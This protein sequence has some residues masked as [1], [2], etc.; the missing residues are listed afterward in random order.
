MRY[1]QYF[2]S[3]T[4]KRVDITLLFELLALNKNLS[5]TYF[6]LLQKK[7][8]KYI[9]HTFA[10][11]HRMFLRPFTQ[12][13]IADKFHIRKN[14]KESETILSTSVLKENIQSLKD[15]SP[16][17]VQITVREDNENT[18]YYLS[19]PVQDFIKILFSEVSKLKIPDFQY[20]IHT[21]N[22]HRYLLEVRGFYPI[23]YRLNVDQSRLSNTILDFGLMNKNGAEVCNK[24]ANNIN[25]FLSVEV[26]Q[27]YYMF[28]SP[29]MK[30]YYTHVKNYMS[31]LTYPYCIMKPIK[32]LPNFGAK[33]VLLY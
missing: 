17:Y 25:T 33:Q 19:I 2:Y 13:E 12:S 26:L 10:V 21:R 32:S 7:L 31:N 18:E 23:Q 9:F 22:I 28:E 15:N 5:E 8:E 4:L 16:I 3:R 20:I 14:S 30:E 29:N 24:I 1:K 6:N 11:Y 27:H